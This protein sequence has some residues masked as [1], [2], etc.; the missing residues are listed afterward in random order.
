MGNG[1]LGEVVR[2]QGA[3]VALSAPYLYN[4]CYSAIAKKRAG[5]A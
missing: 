3:K 2:L 1:T 4:E 5:I